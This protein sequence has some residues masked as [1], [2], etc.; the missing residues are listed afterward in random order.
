MKSE[1]IGN[2]DGVPL[3]LRFVDVRIVDIQ[4][5]SSRQGVNLGTQYCID[6]GFV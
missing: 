6:V 1:N 2:L 3:T 5:K 4:I